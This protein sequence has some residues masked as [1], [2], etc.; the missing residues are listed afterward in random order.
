MASLKYLRRR[1]F[2][3]QGTRALFL[4]ALALSLAAGA[5]VFRDAVSPGQSRG[6]S[7]KAPFSSVVLNGTTTKKG[8][9]GSRGAHGSA[10]T[11]GRNG[12][13]G[14]SG[15]NTSTTAKS[16]NEATLLAE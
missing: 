16:L 5:I 12:A 15:R 7:A 1:V 9:K 10:G 3:H 14:T 2:A 11:R 6:L 4:L 8:T 13:R